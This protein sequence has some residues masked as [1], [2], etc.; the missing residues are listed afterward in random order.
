MMTSNVAIKANIDAASRSWF[1]AWNPAQPGTTSKFTPA[2]VYDSMGV[3]HQVE[4]Y[5]RKT[6]DLA[7]AT[8]GYQP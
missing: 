2:T 3:Q 7:T 1:A 5:F 6:A 8:P 4:I